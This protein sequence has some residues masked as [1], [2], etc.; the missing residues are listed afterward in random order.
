[1][2]LAV[3]PDLV[4]MEAAEEG[5]ADAGFYD[6]ER[7]PRSQIDSFIHGID[8]FI[9]NGVLGDPRGADAVKGQQLMEIAVNSLVRE[10]STIMGQKN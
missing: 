8:H 10:M 7:L 2:M 4:K 1:M 6:K 9:E 3:A 5:L